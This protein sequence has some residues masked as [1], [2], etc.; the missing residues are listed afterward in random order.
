MFP[1]L[2]QAWFTAWADTAFPDLFLFEQSNIRGMLVF[3]GYFS[4]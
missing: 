2:L 1:E 3:P 4:I